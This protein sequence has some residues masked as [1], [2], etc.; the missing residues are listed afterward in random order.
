MIVRVGQLVLEIGRVIEGLAEGVRHN[1]ADA[2]AGVP[3]AGLQRVVRGVCDRGEQIVVH[4]VRPEWLARAIDDGSI[5]AR[6]HG[7]F[8]KRPTGRASRRYLTWLAKAQAKLRV[9]GIV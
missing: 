7:A 8:E 3:Q 6:K 5:L 1:K 2:A 4:K 9:A